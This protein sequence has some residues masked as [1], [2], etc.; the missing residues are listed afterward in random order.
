[1]MM[2]LLSSSPLTTIKSTS[3]Q[4]QKIDLYLILLE[5]LKLILKKKIIKQFVNMTDQILELTLAI[6]ACDKAPSGQEF[7]CRLLSNARAIVQ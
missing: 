6:F 5:I 7:G 2:I 1:M 3:F 4:K